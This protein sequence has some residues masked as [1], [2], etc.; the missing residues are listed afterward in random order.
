VLETFTALDPVLQAFIAGC[1]TWG[2]TL[3]GAAT[4]FLVRGFSQRFLDGMLGFAGGVMIAASFW[5]LLLPSLEMTAGMGHFSWVPVAAGFAA[6]WAFLMVLDRVIPH[7]HIGLPV[8]MAEGT[9]SHLDRTILLVLAITIHNIPEGLAIGVAFG[10]A[11]AGVPE[12]T[13]AG[14]IALTAGIAIQNFPEG[15]AVAYPLCREGLP[16]EQSFFYGQLSAAVEPLAACIGAAVVFFAHSVLPFALAFAAGAMIFVVI[17]EVMPESLQHGFERYALWGF[18]AGFLTM[19]A[20][21]V[22]LG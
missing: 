3:L 12:A 2:V 18:L 6:G 5:S 21:D 17:E 9:P 20:L 8:S 7:L 4:L 1:M 16:R 10:G 15:V 19:M 22:G 11:A 14:A 13:L